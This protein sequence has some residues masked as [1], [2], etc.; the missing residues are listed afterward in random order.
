MP[1]SPIGPSKGMQGPG[2]QPWPQEISNLMRNLQSNLQAILGD[3]RDLQT[4]KNIDQER[5]ILADLSANLA[6][7]E[8]SIRNTEDH[9][10]KCTQDQQNQLQGLLDNINQ[11]I[12]NERQIHPDDIEKIIG[13]M[14]SL[15]A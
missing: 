2:Q 6:K 5:G 1:I 12:A 9:I 15:G 10:Q 4:C 14:Q 3:V 11:A 7:L 8:L 13:S